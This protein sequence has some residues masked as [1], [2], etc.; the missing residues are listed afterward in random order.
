MLTRGDPLCLAH[1]FS[2]IGPSDHLFAG[3]YDSGEK[4]DKVVGQVYQSPHL[5]SAHLDYILLTESADP[6][7]VIPLL[8]G[9]VTKVGHWGAKMVVADLPIDSDLFTQFR[10]AG[11]FTV[12]KQRV[13]RIENRR[14]LRKK[15]NMEWRAWSREDV[16]AMRR[17]Y[18]SVVPPL[19]QPVEPLSRHEM[20]GM[21]YYDAHGALQAYV[22]LVYGPKGVW[23]LPI[24]HPHTEEN[25]VD[26][27]EQMM[28]DLPELIG[29]SVYCAT[30]SYLPWV[31][32]ALSQISVDESPEQAVLVRYL[33]LHQRV[34]PDFG[35][36]SLENG[37]PEPTVP[38]APIKNHRG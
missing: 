7:D 22:D 30:R 33:A 36:L 9:L 21:V 4:S 26:M 18:Q 19:I 11:F 6:S 23:A 24:I 27:L 28:G 34:E 15:S 20:V 32:Q 31:E 35:T 3:V 13:Y 14:T 8:E 1:L 10:Q 17:L 38:L 5:N 16:P 12:A 29:R 2:S 25:R 37:K